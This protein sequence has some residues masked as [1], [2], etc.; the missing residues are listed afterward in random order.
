MVVVVEDLEKKIVVG[1]LKNCL[2]NTKECN[3]SAGVA[4]RVERGGGDISEGSA[5]V[6]MILRN[7][8]IRRG[9][10]YRT[11]LV[12]LSRFVHNSR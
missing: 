1:N 11:V 8:S 2:E 12:A 4:E 5:P 9:E 6:V 3:L 10:R 7:R